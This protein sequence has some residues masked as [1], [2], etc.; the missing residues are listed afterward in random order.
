M[1]P[2]AEIY[3]AGS[4]RMV[5]REALGPKA[6]LT[7]GPSGVLRQRIEQGERPDIF[8]S[9]NMEHARALA[10]AGIYGPVKRVAANGLCL[11]LRPG[12]ETAG[13]GVLELM[14]D[15]GLKLGTSTPGADPGGDYAWGVFAKAEKLEPG[16]QARLEE[17]ARCLVGGPGQR[18]D[19]AGAHP[20]AQLMLQGQADIFLGYRTTAK[21]VLEQAAGSSVLALPEPMRVRTAYGMTL[22]LDIGPRARKVADYL[23]SPPCQTVFARHGFL[24]AP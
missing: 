11:M 17:K 18:F 15:P 4:L 24:T 6:A 20:V 3:C 21:Q 5:L 19:P 22:L 7:P 13:R 2:E 16:A 14:L 12:L 9:A 1:K 23:L 10:A 8:I